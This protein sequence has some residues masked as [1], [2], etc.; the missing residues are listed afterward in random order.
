[1]MTDRFHRLRRLWGPALM[2]FVAACASDVAPTP[3]V[4]PA[5]QLYWRLS[6]N[7]K[8]ANIATAAPFNT[9]QL[10]A[11]PL[12]PDGAPLSDA[13]GATFHSPDPSVSVTPDGLVTGIAQQA[14]TNG[15]I[16]VASLTYGGVTHVDTARVVVTA[17]SGAPPQ[18]AAFH[19]AQA[20]GD[21]TILPIGWAFDAPFTTILV[22]AT[23]ENAQQIDRL[24]VYF[25]TSDSIRASLVTGHFDAPT[26]VIA[27]SQTGPVT[28][29]AFAMAYGVAMSD[30]LKITVTNPTSG[31]IMCSKTA[32]SPDTLF[33]GIGGNAVWQ[34][35]SIYPDSADIKFDVP[36]EVSES[37]FAPSGGG[38]IPAVPQ[39]FVVRM[40]PHAG[41]YHYHSTRFP[42]LKGVI[43]VR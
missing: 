33:I 35:G 17:L 36:T 24:K 29:R 31:L 32:V 40:F 14:G 23:D 28:V 16:V 12:S 37:P 1:M 3:T 41:T 38:D 6:I 5:D 20:P 30:S 7:H 21:S 42:V 43:V 4:V 15:A 13:S 9:V 27:G 10:V 19:I 18:L 25:E 8:A 11:T 39:I 22:D 2:T 26:T 34:V